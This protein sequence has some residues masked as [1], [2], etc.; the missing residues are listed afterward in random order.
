MV[1]R[2]FIRKQT[3]G[4]CVVAVLSNNQELIVESGALPYV[5]ARFLYYVKDRTQL[6]SRVR[7]VLAADASDSTVHTA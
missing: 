7:E 2:F 4:F 1:K 6:E 3:N 5:K